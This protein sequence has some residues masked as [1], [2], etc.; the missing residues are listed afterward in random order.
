MTTVSDPTLQPARARI[1]VV[2]LHT[3][4]LDQPGTG[5]SGG[6]NVEIRALARRLADRGVAVDVYT[7][8]AGRGVPEVERLGSKARVIQ[9]PAGPCAPVTKDALPALVPSFV[10]SVVARAEAEGPY[11]LVHAHY[12]LSGRAASVA[13]A[14]WGI[15]LVASFHTLAE[16]KNRAPGID[17]R[18]PAGRIDSERETL[19][20][21]DLVL[22]PSPGE[23]ENLVRLYQADPA[24]I[25][26]VPPGVDAGRFR[27]RDR[28]DVADGLGLSGRVAMFLGRLQPLKGADVAIRAVARAR[29]LAPRITDDLVLA[30]VGGPSGQNASYV[31][32]LRRLASEEG[33]GDRVTFLDP[34]P[35]EELPWV[36]PAAEV[37]LMP[38][39]SESFGLAALEAQAC[40]VPVVAASVGGLRWV[41]EDGATGFLVPGHDPE[42]YARRLVEILAD[43]SLAA[44]MSA[45]A[46]A[47]ARR[48]S[49]ERTVD[50]VVDAY[51][52]LIPVPA[53][54]AS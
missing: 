27:P 24:R 35:H 1:A 43:P 8:C 29:A 2:S 22:A 23:A 54:L 52:E 10:E 31:D 49:W 12:W 6:M 51:A 34:R 7:R 3:S 45:G 4:P 39:R 28:S 47:R 9:V 13:Q 30:V 41:V 37:M 53:T 26:V 20:A 40:G 42:A 15:P 38:S 33:I 19:E 18:E 36:Y 50:G 5:D 44:R 32:R 48:F 16:V 25:R 11:D 17:D 21:A 46:R 14:R